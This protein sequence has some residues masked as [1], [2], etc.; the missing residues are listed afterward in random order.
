M[1]VELK[2]INN[3]IKKYMMKNTKFLLMSVLGGAV[4]MFVFVLAPSPASASSNFGS[5]TLRYGSTGTN[6]VALQQLLASDRDMY[7]SGSTDGKFGTNT[8]NAVIQFQIAYGLN[9][10]GAF[11]RNS[12]DVANS[13][14]DAG[15]GVDVSGPIMNNLSV[16]TSGRNSYI[17]FNTNEPVKAVVFYDTN[18]INWNNWDDSVMS[19][20]T[21]NISGMSVSDNT[22]GTTKQLSLTNLLANTTYNYVVVVTDQSGNMSTIWPNSLRTTQ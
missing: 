9:A 7:P 14:M 2:T 10:D 22:F 18:S 1:S 17:S 19:L 13:V 21:P 8:K 16:N 4:F 20:N 11:G 3:F 12:M 15:R 6:V 5:T